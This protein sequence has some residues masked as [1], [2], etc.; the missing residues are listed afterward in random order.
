MMGQLLIVFFSVFLALAGRFM[1]KRGKPLNVRK[2]WRP[3][4]GGRLSYNTSSKVNSDIYLVT[5]L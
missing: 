2:G 4:R 3:G 1:R 5:F